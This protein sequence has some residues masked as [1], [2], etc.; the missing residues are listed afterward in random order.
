MR[1]SLK[2]CKRIVIKVGTSTLMYPNG[3][4]NLRT[5]EKLAMVL[6][7]LCNEGKEVVLV[8]SGAI[9]VGCHKLQLPT[10]PTEMPDL[11][12]IAAVGQSE[13]MNIYNKFFGEYG[14][15][16]GQV[17][18]T[19]DVI[20]YPTSRKNVINTFNK[21]L[22]NRI[23][24]IVNENDTVAIEEIEHLTKFGDNDRLSAIVL[25]VIQADL[26]IMLS[27]IDGFYDSN[28][29]DNPDSKM[30]TEIHQI[31]PE[32]QSL[33]G[34]KGSAF[35]TGGMF[36]KLAAADKVLKNDSKMVLTNGNQPAI[37]FD[38]MNGKNIGTLFAKEALVKGET[39]Q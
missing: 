30:F 34:G 3:N 12:A 11:Q 17:L 26:L 4:V 32:L 27:D 36:T 37:I 18:L 22:E 6:S 19:R 31:T 15:T 28:P 16:V 5:I 1:A 29:T 2:N 33:A 10:R 39:G 38:I 23:I 21:L 7:D 8:S 13:L 35:G 25:E 24:P 14:Y 20:D 9:G